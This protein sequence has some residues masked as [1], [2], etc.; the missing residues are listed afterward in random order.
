MRKNTFSLILTLFIAFLLVYSGQTNA[1]NILVFTDRN[2]YFVDSPVEINAEIET[3]Q[4]ELLPIDE[5]SIIIKNIDDDAYQTK[6]VLSNLEEGLH[7]ECSQQDSRFI[8]VNI[9]RDDFGYGY[10]YGYGFN[11]KIKVKLKWVYSNWPAGNYT[12]ILSL[13]SGGQEIK[14]NATFKG[15]EKFGTLAF[16]CRTDECNYG[17]EQSMIKFFTENG[18]DVVGKGYWSWSSDIANYKLIVCSDELRACKIDP[19]HPAYAAHK[20]GVPFLEIADQPYAQAAYRFGYAK[21][22][23][24]TTRQEDLFITQ[25]HEITQ[26]FY[27][28]V[29]ILLGSRMNVIPDYQLSSST[30]D[31]ADSGNHSSSTLF[32]ANNYAYIGW[33]NDKDAQSLTDDGATIFNR[34]LSWLTFSSVE[35]DTN[36][37]VVLSYSPSNAINTRKPLI[38]LNTNENA[39]CRFSF[40]QKTYDQM[41]FEFL[42][43]EPMHEYQFNVELPNG[44]YT[45]YARCKDLSGN[46]MPLVSWQFSINLPEYKDIA[47]IC[48]T[49]ECNYGIEQQMIKWLES[50]GWTVESKGYWS[51]SSDIA[52]YKLIVCSDELRACKIDPSHPAYAA[53]KA[54]VPFLEIADQPYAQAAYRFGYVKNY[55]GF[56]RS[57]SL[58]VTRNH[59]I[60]QNIS[61]STNILP[62]PKLNVIQDYWLSSRVI[63]LADSGNHSSS[64]LFVTDDYAYVGWFGANTPQQLTPRGSLILSRIVHWLVS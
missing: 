37:P 24:G 64:T 4:Q 54:G 52:N 12:A 42:K 32:M 30:I 26:G 49:D 38:T 53:H 51:W 29:D 35:E 3:G 46:E 33:F 7:E 22:Y 13:K 27:G 10:G 18:W 45:V 28:S 6:C 62:N 16:I 14:T 61:G 56:V 39:V 1:F 31:L 5:A 47:F 58:H 20:A 60:T 55:I 15:R 36:P 44:V 57:E 48:R 50:K 25:Q 63:D 34:V 43:N 9:E 19:S 40:S 17:I 23:I 2:Y 11:G 59:Y 8:S 21:S 41:E